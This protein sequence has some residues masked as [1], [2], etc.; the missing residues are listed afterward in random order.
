MKKMLTGLLFMVTTTAFGADDFTLR[1]I[2][3]D[4]LQRVA[5]GAAMLSMPL[6]VGDRVNDDDI[7]NTIRALFATGNFEDVQVLRDGDTLLIKVKERPAIASISFSGNKAIKEEQLKQNL[8]ATGVRVGEALD[9]TMLSSI[10]K[11][12][13]DFYY[14]VGKYTAS[15]KAVVTPLPRNRV[16]LKFIFTEGVSAKIQ[17]I[18]IVGNHAFS[19]DE[20]ISRFQLRDDVPWWNFIADQKYQKEKLSGDL[21]ALRSFYLDRGYA[22]FNIDSTQVSLTPDRKGIYITVNIN[23]GDVY[24][25]SGVTVTGDLAGHS[26]EIEKLAQIPKGGLYSGAQITQNE[27]AIKDLLGRYG[28]AFPQVSTQPEINDADKTVKLHVNVDAGRRFYVRK[29]RFEGN[30]T[31]KDSVLRREM[32]QMEGSWL[33]NNLVDQGKARLN[34][35]GYFETVDVDT[36][37]VP[38]TP[39]QVDVVYKVKERNTGTFNIGVGY[40]TDSGVSF[41]LGV[42]QDNWMGTGNTVGFSGTKNDYQTYVEVSATNPYFTVDGVSLGGKLFY[43]DYKADDD[44]LSEYTLKSLGAGTTLSFPIS[45]NNSINTGL[46]YVF[47]RVSNMEPQVSMW[48]YLASQGVHPSVVT[49]TTDD[50]GT[51]DETFTAN[52]FF[53]N[54]GWSYNSLDRGFFPTSGVSAGFNTKVTIP[55]STNSYYKSTVSANA[56]LPLSNDHR[57]VLMGRTKA[58]YADGLGGKDVPFYDNFYAGGSSSVRGFSSNTIGPKAAYYRCNGTESSY[59]TCP[60]EKSDDAVGGN[61]M[62]IASA[63]LIVPT[64]FVSER[65]ES[66][67]RTS[68]FVDAGTVWDT[69]WEN[70]A[71]TRAAGIPDYGDPSEIR[72]SSGLAL[73][74]QSPLGPLVFSYALPIKKYEG[75]KSEQFQFNIGKTW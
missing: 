46:D 30:D 59:G 72:V 64:P 42:S 12:L 48:R 9:R 15:V 20:L 69:K 71:A 35:T 34:R 37:R 16:D 38:G 18:N 32:R 24:H 40:G 45:E 36:Q 11:G 33:A 50:D 49:R 28:Y 8:D 53:W 74:W 2:H 39:D 51:S 5:P 14:S 6:R 68:L 63:E 47:N 3:F 73:Q 44:D 41:Q 66:S 52:D 65:Y 75:D 57:W 61:A 25:V 27:N 67:L 13:E 21:E 62:A 56:Y 43:N 31:S 10:E 17:Q 29:V 7:K 23:E 58:G 55:G 1:D 26:A 19:D 4:G 22:R 70:T 54:V 60:V